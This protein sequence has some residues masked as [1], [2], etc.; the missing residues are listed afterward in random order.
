MA[1][2][3]VMLSLFVGLAQANTLLV[4]IIGPSV[5]ETT[6]FEPSPELI[7][8]LL[9]RKLS[10]AKSGAVARVERPQFKLKSPSIYLPAGSKG[11]MARA[12][13]GAQASEQPKKMPPTAVTGEVPKVDLSETITDGV[14]ERL[15]LDLASKGH[16]LPDP[17]VAPPAHPEV[18]LPASIERFIG[19]GFHDW[20][21]V[22]EAASPDA[23]NQLELAR[24]LMALDPDEPYAI[25]TVA[26]Y[27]YLSEEFGLCKDLYSRYV[28]LFPDDAAGWNNLALTY[29]RAGEYG[30][31]ERLYRRALSIEP[32]NANT[33]NNLALSL[34][35]QGQYLEAEALMRR[36]QPKAHERP[37]ANLHRAKIAAAQ[38]KDRKAYRFLRRALSDVSVMDTVHHIEFRQ[39]IRLDPSLARLRGT[40]KLK[41]LLLAVYGDDI[42]VGRNPPTR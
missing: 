15:I 34:A 25:L 4:A 27:A 13:G 17:T 12:G 32:N 2:L 42:P 28:H 14:A 30:E 41:R 16:T 40:P 22:S 8:R 9:K 37:F 23:N 38:G 21:E 35:H 39:D 7:A 24:R 1:L 36:L 3:V 18:G 31:E 5:A 6:T 19:W 20:M 10:G 29:K 11:P 26:Y 33:I